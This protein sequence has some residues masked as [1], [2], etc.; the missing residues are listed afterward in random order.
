MTPTSGSASKRRPPSD[1]EPDPG[2]STVT[3]YWSAHELAEHLQRA[4]EH[5]AAIEQAKGILMAR[6]ACSSDA[7]FDVRR[8]ASQR[9]NRTLHDIAVELVRRTEDGT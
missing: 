8:R 7:A 4:M 6:H 2:W 5:R 1:P 9:E 3:A